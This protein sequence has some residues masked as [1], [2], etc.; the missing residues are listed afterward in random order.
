MLDDLRFVLD[1][2]GDLVALYAPYIDYS[3]ASCT[4]VRGVMTGQQ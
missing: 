3:L 2:N 1:A 4:T